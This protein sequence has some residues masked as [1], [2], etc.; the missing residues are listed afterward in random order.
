MLDNKG[1]YK[2]NDTIIECKGE[3][4]EGHLKRVLS[5]QEVFCHPVLLC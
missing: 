2:N 3:V 5:C 1:S 4:K